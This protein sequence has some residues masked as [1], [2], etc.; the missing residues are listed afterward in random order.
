MLIIYRRTGG[1]FVLLAVAAVALAATVLTIAVA[2]TLVVAAIAIAGVVLLGR[3][4]L[5]RSWLD[6]TGPPAT[7][8]PDT[9]IDA[10]V[11][12]PTHSSDRREPP[13]L[14]GDTR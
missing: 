12:T 4:V 13:R 7:P 1:L 8:W 5:P 10:R 9:T 6:R 14:D 2:A 3:A 11:V